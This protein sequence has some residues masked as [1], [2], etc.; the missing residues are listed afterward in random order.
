MVNFEIVSRINVTNLNK[1]N[2][3]KKFIFALF[4]VMITAAL[5][6]VGIADA[7]EPTVVVSQKIKMEKKT[8]VP[9]KGSGFAPG[10]KIKL[11]VIIDGIMTNIADDLEPEPMVNESGAWDTSWDC[12]RHISKKLIKQGSYQLSVTDEDYNP[13]AKTSIDF[14][15]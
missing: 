3:M 8:Q 2:S 13:L 5:V 12:S 14:Y 11:V 10:Q 4:A 7:K 9:I 1:E 6:N 15:K